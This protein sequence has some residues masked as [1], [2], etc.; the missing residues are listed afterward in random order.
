M[1]TGWILTKM[2]DTEAG[3]KPVIASLSAAYRPGA[4]PLTEGGWMLCHVKCDPA[5]VEYMKKDTED[6]LWIGGDYS[7]VPQVVLDTYASKLDPE[8]TYLFI[9]QVVQKL[10]EWEP[11]FNMRAD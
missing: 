7:K 5:I 4:V 6:F 2:D 11:R 9:G 1:V 10:A 8:E 3:P